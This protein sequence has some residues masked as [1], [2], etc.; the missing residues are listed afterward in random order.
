MNLVFKFLY[1]VYRAISGVRYWGY[2]RFTRA[3]LTV[4]AGL[5]ITGIFRP[6]QRQ[7]C[8]LPGFYLSV[9]SADPRILPRVSF[10]VRA[11]RLRACFPVSERLEL[12]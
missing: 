7:Q 5:I 4:L 8:G 10:S 3:G 9:A 2:R 11:F 6:G 12:L 1:R